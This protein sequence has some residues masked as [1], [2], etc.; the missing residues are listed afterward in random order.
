MDML[1]TEFKPNQRPWIL[2]IFTIWRADHYRNSA[3]I[4]TIIQLKNEF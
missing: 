1:I 3:K 2:T 4:V